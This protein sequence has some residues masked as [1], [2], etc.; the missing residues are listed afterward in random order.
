MSK[1]TRSWTWIATLGIGLL[2]YVWFF[3]MQTLFA[4]ETRHEGRKV[5]ILNSVPV[6]LEDLSISNAHGEKLS[7]RGAEFEVPWNDV[8]EDKT[9]IVGNLLGIFFRSGRSILLWVGP[10]DIF[11]KG[12]S[13]DKNVDPDVFARTYGP[14]VLRSDYALQKAIFETTPSQ[15]TPFTARSKAAG[16]MSIIVVK[17]VMPPTSDW[18]IYSVASN[19]FKGFQL[20]NPARR[21]SRMCLELYRDDAHFEIVI[22]Q[23][24]VGPNP[25]I[26]QA[27]LNRIIQTTHKTASAQST[28]TMKPV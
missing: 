23:N 5:P 24:M 27:E 2:A 22:D 25:G 3:G 8:D 9:R 10:E 19:E 11:I 21:P 7:F 18:G 6:A 28:F 4:V 1:W 17:A 16:L 20:G 12:L 13:R 14:E 15:I 26:T